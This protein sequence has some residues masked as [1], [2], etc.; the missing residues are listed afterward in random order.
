MPINVT[1]LLEAA[2]GRVAAGEQEVEDPTKKLDI[3]SLLSTISGIRSSGRRGTS[4]VQ[5]EDVGIVKAFGAGVEFGIKDPLRF[6]GVRPREVILDETSEKVANFLGSMVGL[7][8]SFVPF[9][10]GTGVALRGIGLTARIA[11]AGAGTVAV[12][13]ANRSQALFN[14]TRNTIAGSVQF[15]GSAEEVEEIPGKLATGA[16]FGAAIEAVFLKFALKGRRGAVGSD[17]L[18][19]DGNT[20][21]DNPLSLDRAV[22]E[23]EISPSANKTSSRMAVELEGLLEGKDYE[24]IIVDLMQEHVETSRYTGLSKEGAGDLANYARTNLPDAQILTRKTQVKGVHEVLIHQ[25]FDPEDVLTTTQ[26]KQWGNSGFAE[27]E[28]VFYRGNMFAA[29]GVGTAPGKVQLKLPYSKAQVFAA[30]I[31]E[32]TRPTTTRFFKETRR[33]TIGL[34]RAIDDL[35]KKVGF[36]V[37]STTVRTGASL[38]ARRGFVN[39]A[40]FE[41]VGS[42]REFAEQF[43]ERLATVQAANAEE[44][45]GILARQDGIAG[46]L[47]KEEGITTKIHV[48]DQEVVS[49]VTEPPQLART[50]SEARPIG[51]IAGPTEVKVTLKTDRPAPTTVPEALAQLEESTVEGLAVLE[52]QADAIRAGETT[53]EVTLRGQMRASQPTPV[54][55][56]A[57][58]EIPNLGL[59]LDDAVFSTSLQG[60]P[61]LSSFVPSWRNS[62]AGPLREAGIPEKEIAQYLDLFV[63]QSKSNLESLLEPEFLAIKKASEV[64]FGG[65]P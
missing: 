29:T 31:D 34:R 17:H 46:L 37:P 44:A 57:R 62:I 63:A 36:V 54:G 40:E 64:Q 60:E 4:T 1:Q 32:V 35:D 59:I 15:A 38:S 26:M 33:R 16:V 55:T 53:R 48:F 14:F 49:F 65:C 58:P 3:A 51:D 20:I 5:E 61:I 24:Q 41:T 42:F 2:S 30:S 43:T 18:V 45:V 56:R 25:P 11:E 23:T 13:A 12:A 7:G 39:V 50:A 52:R 28:E 9:A 27:G 8:I 47:I 6:V 19:P 22:L 21:P 10:F